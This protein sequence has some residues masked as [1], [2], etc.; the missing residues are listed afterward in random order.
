VTRPQVFDCFTFMNELDL[1]EIRL[2]ELASVV[3]HFVLVE[4]T[5]TFSGKEKPLVFHENR[6]R[7]AKFLHKIVH[8][9]LAYL[10]L[11]PKNPW[12][13]EAFQR[14]AILR[15]LTDARSDDLVMISD[16]DE[17][18]RAGAV[19]SF[20]GAAGAFVQTWYY[21]KL[22]CENVSGQPPEPLSVILRAGL[23]A[24]P[25]DVR[26]HR[27]E[28][29]PIQ[30]GGWH[31]SYLGDETTIREKIQAFSHQE[32]NEERF[33]DESAIRRRVNAGEDLFDRPGFAWRFVP[34]DERFP[35]FVRENRSNL[36][37]LIHEPVLEKSGS[38]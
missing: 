4:A 27:H 3:D 9:P 30:E 18:P 13:L 7:F 19:A 36:S 6:E 24:T 10:P 23:L 11:A 2:E 25:Q 29:V 35:R 26:Y 15:G 28:L 8:V 37:H 21:Y 12:E 31:F 22:N 17:I 5:K 34:L 38:P 14:N 33:T 20:A 16:L 1:L 32:L